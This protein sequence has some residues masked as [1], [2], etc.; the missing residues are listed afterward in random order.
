MEKP[1]TIETSLTYLEVIFLSNCYGLLMEEGKYK[2]SRVLEPFIIPFD[3][4]ELGL[5]EL[6][7]L[8]TAIL[9]FLGNDVVQMNDITYLIL[10]KIHK[11]LLQYNN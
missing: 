2:R 9:N 7:V 3:I 4:G 1:L 5:R 8:R 11:C 6:S 10:A